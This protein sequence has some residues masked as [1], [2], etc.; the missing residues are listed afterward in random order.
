MTGL[1]AYVVAAHIND[2]MAESATERLASAAR[3]QREP[4]KVA[5]AVRNAWSLL[6]G[7]TEPTAL[8]KL[9]DYPYRS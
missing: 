2:L 5:G 6:R 9:T 1:R 4:G 3:S 7:S 8:P